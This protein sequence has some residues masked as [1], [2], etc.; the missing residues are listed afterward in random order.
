MAQK[1]RRYGWDELPKE[2]VRAGVKRAGFRGDNAL[3]VM[4]WLEP[5]METNP[6]SHPFEQTSTSCRAGCGFTSAMTL[7]KRDRAA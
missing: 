5:G 7:S 1:A 4:N 6:H 2:T 3:L